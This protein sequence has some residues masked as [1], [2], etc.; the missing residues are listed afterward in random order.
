MPTSDGVMSIE[1]YDGGEIKDSSQRKRKLKYV[2]PNVTGFVV[3]QYL[4]KSEV[5]L[6]LEYLQP[7]DSPELYNKYLE[8]SNIFNPFDEPGDVFDRIIAY[9]EWGVLEGGTNSSSDDRV[10]IVSEWCQYMGFFDSFSPNEL[11]SAFINNK[12]RSKHRRPTNRTRKPDDDP[13]DVFDRLVAFTGWGVME[14]TDVSVKDRLEIVSEWCTK[15]NLFEPAKSILEPKLKHAASHMPLSQELVYSFCPVV[16][17]NQFRFLN[18]HFHVINVPAD[19]NCGYYVGLCSLYDNNLLDPEISDTTCLRE[20]LYN[21]ANEHPEISCVEASF[22]GLTNRKYLEDQVFPHLFDPADPLRLDGAVDSEFHLDVMEILP[23]FVSCF[24]VDVTV[25]ACDAECEVEM[26]HVF[27]HTGE[28]PE[29]SAVAGMQLMDHN[30]ERPILFFIQKSDHFW[31][32][33][34]T[35]IDY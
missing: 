3:H 4:L 31:Y 26:T 33:K 34:P 32:G 10:D 23:I 1:S 6:L 19:G 29:Y 21:F 20:W 15:M 18:Q 30:S 5:D 28:I 7:D 24:E 11:Q 17:D 8:A 25:Y 2:T 22:L 9:T 13:A 27:K 14:N 12:H 35:Q 16:L